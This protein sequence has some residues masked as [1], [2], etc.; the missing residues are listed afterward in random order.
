MHWIGR[1]MVGAIVLSMLVVL[2][3]RTVAHEDREIL[4]DRY[5]LTVG[6]VTEP[7]YVGQ[8]NGVDLRVVELV[9]D[10]STPATGTTE[11][12]NVMTVPVRDLQSKLKVEVRA[13]GAT[14]PLELQPASRAGSY[15]ATFLPTVPGNYTFQ[16]TGEIAGQPVDETFGSSPETFPAVAPVT[17]LQFPITVPVGDNLNARFAETDDDIARTRTLALVAVA[18]GAVGLLGG[19][20]ALALS[21]RP[22][23]SGLVPP[24]DQ[25]TGGQ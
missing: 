13:Q 3:D 1:G 22:P 16:I 10:P 7:P 11:D 19:G 12:D 5:R 23:P 25:D 2:P 20:L 8:P 4:G 17:D 24:A 21:R 15:R 18:A 14:A 9:P 6:F